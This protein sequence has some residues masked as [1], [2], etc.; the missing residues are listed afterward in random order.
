MT[1]ERLLERYPLTWPE[2]RP[3]T[4]TR[5]ASR[6]ELGFVDARDRLLD[7]LRRLGAR[8]VVISSNVPLRR[9][10]L[11]VADAREPADPG[12]AV[13]FERRVG[14]RSVPFVIACDTYN[15]VK[16]NLRA[17]GLTVEALRSIERHGASELLE[18]AFTGF[19]ALPPAQLADPPWWVVLG[20]DQNADMDTIR[21]ARNLLA[22]AHHPD[23]GGD[24]ERMAQINRAYE[25]AQE[26]K[27]P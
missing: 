20:V 19:A 3:R 12:V 1:A 4:R 14:D 25:R 23:R 6:F 21:G 7:E 24:A 16:A 27:K 17:I 9:D 11:P 18:Q 10:G 13:Y 26:P 2:G 15:R 8:D 5:R 22:L